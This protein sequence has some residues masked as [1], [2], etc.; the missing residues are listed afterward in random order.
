MGE[1]R[2]KKSLM[3][4]SAFS[5]TRTSTVKGR[6]QGGGLC[7]GNE[8][9]NEHVSQDLKECFT[10]APVSTGTVGP[11]PMYLMHSSV[12]LQCKERH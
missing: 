3:S 4:I 1:Q 2:G 7:R 12:S 6:L 11:K 10:V 9:T 8:N 5:A